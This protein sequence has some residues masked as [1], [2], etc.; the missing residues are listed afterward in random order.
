MSS[1]RD[2]LVVL[3]FTDYNVFRGCT[4][5]LFEAA[6]EN[7]FLRRYLKATPE[8]LS[9]LARMEEWCRERNVEPRL[10]LHF[11]FQMRGWRFSPKLTTADLCSEKA[12]ARFGKK[13]KLSFFRQHT[14]AHSLVDRSDA[15]FDPN[16][17]TTPSVEALKLG[18]LQSGQAQRCLD[19]QL[20]QT[21]G[22]HPRSAV[23]LR[24]PLAC[25][26]AV[27]LEASVP[28]SLHAVRAGRLTPADAE[29]QARGALCHS[30]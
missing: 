23:C 11:L 17:D 16:R 1:Q 14:Q 20:V 12:L 21:L 7:P 15:G 25:D 2:D 3:L 24:C 13:A 27:R 5:H 8:R 6:K 30:R 22:Y 26:C 29:R 9:V 10:W 19:E 4:H 18:Y 28:F